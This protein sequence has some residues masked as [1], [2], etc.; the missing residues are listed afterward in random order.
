MDRDK[1]GRDVFADAELTRIALP[2]RVYTKS[3][4]EFAIDRI[5]WL[6][7]HRDLVKGLRFVSEPPVLRF[8]FGKLEPLDDWGQNLKEAFKKEMGNA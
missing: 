4:I 3:H 5:E 6:Y 8:F 7:R 1:E 2:R